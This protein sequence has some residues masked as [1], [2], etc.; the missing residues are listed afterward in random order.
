MRMGEYI[1]TFDDLAE[2]SALFEIPFRKE[3]ILK[4]IGRGKR[5]LDVG[6][7]GGQ[8]SKLIQ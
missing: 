5:V 4:S 8:I 6:C 1:E 7:L 3:F 2:E